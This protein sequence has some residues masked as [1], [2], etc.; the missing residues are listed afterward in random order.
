MIE[1]DHCKGDV[2]GKHSRILFKPSQG[3]RDL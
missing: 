1:N 2:N 3:S